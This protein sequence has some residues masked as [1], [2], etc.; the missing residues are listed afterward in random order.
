MVNEKY[1]DILGSMESLIKEE[2]NVKDVEYVSELGEYI[3]YEVRPNLPVAGPKYGRQL[4][5]IISALA[6]LDANKVVNTLKSEGRVVIVLDGEEIEL[7]EED[8]DIRIKPREGF[9]VEVEN[10]TFVVLDTDID[11]ELMLEGI[12][13]EL[14]SK[15]QNLRKNAGF[16]VIDHINMILRCDDTVQEAVK[17]HI[18]LSLIHI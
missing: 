10:D 5:N 18:D 14:V 9:A 1:K 17:K 6:Q 16:D 4:Q 13:R 12:A 15:I 8:I 2:L 11:H 3:S 7:T